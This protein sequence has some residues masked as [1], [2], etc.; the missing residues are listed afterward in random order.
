MRSWRHISGAMARPLPDP[1]DVE[2]WIFDLDNTLYPAHCDLFAQVS[3]RM[4]EYIADFLAIDVAAAKVLQKDYFR[5]HGT[6]LRGLMLEHAM[7]PAPFL[8]Y[9]HDI[10]LSVVPVDGRL[11][12]ALSALPGRKLIFTNGNDWH[13]QRVTKHLGIDHHF[14]AVFDIAASDYV[15]KPDPGPYAKLVERHDIRP[16]ATVMIEDIARNLAPAAA[17]GMTTVWVP[18]NAEWSTEGMD[19]DHVHHVADDL[20]DW[21]AGLLAPVRPGI[22]FE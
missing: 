13:A 6:T 17:L 12:R 2:V 15:P 22:E 21:L 5:R 9:V 20:A 11:D 8:D 3:T 19:D 14:D 16:E 10:D 4:G 7:D 18:G 1:K